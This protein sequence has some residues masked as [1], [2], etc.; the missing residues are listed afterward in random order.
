L[1][2]AP[3]SVAEAGDQEQSSGEE[4]AT[5]ETQSGGGLTDNMGIIVLGVA[6]VLIILAGAGV[7]LLRRG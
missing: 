7:Y 4:A 3:E 6:G 2:A 1:Q 5:S